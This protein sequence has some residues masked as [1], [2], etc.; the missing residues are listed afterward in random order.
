MSSM[1]TSSWYVTFI[2]EYLVLRWPCII[3]I[4]ISLPLCS[5]YI[6][7]C[8]ELKYRCLSCGCCWLHH[9]W[10]CCQANYLLPIDMQKWLRTT[11]L[12]SLKNLMM[13]SQRIFTSLSSMLPSDDAMLA[14]T[15]TI[16]V[17]FALPV[18]NTAVVMWTQMTCKWCLSWLYCHTFP[19]PRK[20]TACFPSSHRWTMCVTTSP[21]R[22]AQNENFYIWRCFSYLRCR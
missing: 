9:C 22:V 8:A 14:V 21:Q 6:C 11:T 4:T 10:F 20:S 13:V 12:L 7:V 17:N 2:N 1:A 18:Y 16:L 15:L 5:L 19:L 3:A